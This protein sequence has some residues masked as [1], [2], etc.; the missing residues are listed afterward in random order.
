[1]WLTDFRVDYICGTYGFEDIGVR[2][3][4]HKKG[5]KVMDVV[6]MLAG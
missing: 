1:M 4:L 5:G 2:D 6:Q 3:A